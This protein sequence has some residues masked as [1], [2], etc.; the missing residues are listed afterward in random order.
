MS[1][2][3]I[4]NLCDSFLKLYFD[5]SRKPVMETAQVHTQVIP[6]PTSAP[7]LGRIEF[8]VSLRA[9]EEDEA[10]ITLVSRAAESGGR[11][12]RVYRNDK[13]AILQS[14]RCILDK[15]ITQGTG[16]RTVQTRS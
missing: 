15:K 4:L 14:R 6:W 16:F 13:H 8:E 3:A 12:L 2:A 10:R 5:P 9:L 11:E 7:T 1:N